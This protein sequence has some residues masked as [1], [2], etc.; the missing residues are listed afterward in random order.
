MKGYY[1]IMAALSLFCFAPAE[2]M[3][4]VP[5]L[6]KYQSNLIEFLIKY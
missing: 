3:E 1:S 6:V 2:G 5:N 4:V